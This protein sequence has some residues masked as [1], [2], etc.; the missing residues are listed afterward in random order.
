MILTLNDVAELKNIL[1]KR[2]SA[3]LHFHDCCGGQYFTVDGTND[4]L[5]SFLT[6]YF[7]E[8]KLK[9][10]FSENGDSFSVE[11]IK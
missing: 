11:E 10:N 5:K 8:R 7:S 6:D 3:R 4:E 9:V 2:F 1:E